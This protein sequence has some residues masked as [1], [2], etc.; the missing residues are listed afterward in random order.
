MAKT[1][2][3]LTLQHGAVSITLSKRQTAAVAMVQSAIVDGDGVSA[4]VSQNRQIRDYSAPAIRRAEFARILA[5]AI[6]A[7][8][9]NF[10]RVAAWLNREMFAQAGD[11]WHIGAGVAEVGAA[12]ATLNQWA[13]GK[14][15]TT[16]RTEK[17][18]ERRADMVAGVQFALD[19]IREVFAQESAGTIPAF[20][21]SRKGKADA[22]A[23][24][25]ADA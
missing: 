19:A 21:P 3:T 15:D 9:A 13:A 24:V 6:K 1:P 5:G 14:Y 2:A 25:T 11:S 23:P 12:Q 22:P 20:S 10:S 16:A 18:L 8:P 17:T 7:R 4:A